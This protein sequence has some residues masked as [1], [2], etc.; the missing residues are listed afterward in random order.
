MI[1]LL[2]GKISLSNSTGGSVSHVIQ[3]DVTLLGGTN[4]AE[5]N[6]TSQ[7][8]WYL[9]D[10]R[11]YRKCFLNSSHSS[12]VAVRQAGP[13]AACALLGRLSDAHQQHRCCH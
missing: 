13:A 12:S 10:F 1:R 6:G 4:R 7:P 3:R 9:L 8:D 11:G 2:A 5:A